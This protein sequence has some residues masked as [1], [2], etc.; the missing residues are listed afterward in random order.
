[1]PR[2]EAWID[3][4][5]ICQSGRLED[6]AQRPRVLI[7]PAWEAILI[8]TVAKKWSEGLNI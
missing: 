1:M 3:R 5:P 7:T 6:I 8:I 2:G 4:C